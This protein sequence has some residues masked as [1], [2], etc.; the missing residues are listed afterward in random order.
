M[1][2]KLKNDPGLG[3]LTDITL[4]G[5]LVENQKSNDG[6]ISTAQLNDVIKEGKKAADKVWSDDWTLLLSRQASNVSNLN[7]FKDA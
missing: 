6:S 2:E 4:R 7:E 3:Q 5:F 1:L